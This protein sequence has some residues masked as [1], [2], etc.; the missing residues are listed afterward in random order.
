LWYRYSSV[1]IL[2]KLWFI[3][4]LFGENV[5]IEALQQSGAMSTSVHGMEMIE[6]LSGISSS[7]AVTVKTTVLMTPEE[8]DEVAKQITN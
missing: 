1:Q 6:E 3:H 2:K 8:I 4:T 7:G 5:N